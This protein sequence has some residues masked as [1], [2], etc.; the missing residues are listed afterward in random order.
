MY[1]RTWVGSNENSL[2]AT[3]TRPNMKDNGNIEKA[4]SVQN[5][6]RFDRS[7]RYIVEKQ[8]EQ[9]EF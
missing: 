2:R 5:A 1:L 3:C 9:Q 4:K 6:R 7:K 8:K